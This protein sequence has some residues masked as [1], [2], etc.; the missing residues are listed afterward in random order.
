MISNSAVES[1]DLRDVVR[2]VRKSATPPSKATCEF[3]R[4]RIIGLNIT[5]Q[6]FITRL[7]RVMPRKNKTARSHC[8][9]T[10]SFKKSPPGSSDGSDPDPDCSPKSS[11][12]HCSKYIH[13]ILIS[14]IIIFYSISIIEVEK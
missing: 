9:T 13:A 3:L 1:M 8:R 14:L 10:A 6:K 7:T 4:K 2:N 11:Y 5:L 12:P